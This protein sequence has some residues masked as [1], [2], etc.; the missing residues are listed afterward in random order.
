MLRSMGSLRVAYNLAI[1]QYQQLL[2]QKAVKCWC[3]EVNCGLCPPSFHSVW[4]S[5]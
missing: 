5:V 3:E 2:F 4:G 1:E